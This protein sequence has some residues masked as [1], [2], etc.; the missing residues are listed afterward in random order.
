MA[1][2]ICVVTV[3]GT[4]IA[5]GTRDLHVSPAWIFPSS[6]QPGPVTLLPCP[7]GPASHS[8]CIHETNKEG[9][10][11]YHD[12]TNGIGEIPT[13]FSQRFVSLW[14]EEELDFVGILAV[15]P[16]ILLSVPAIFPFSHLRCTHA[17]PQHESQTIICLYG[18]LSCFVTHG[19]LNAEDH[20][21]NCPL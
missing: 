6:Y 2:D 4:C 5:F 15:G 3:L 11:S 1:V 20:S 14:E 13:S 9:Q 10:G 16:S 8:P 12:G 18:Q 19:P 17:G 21:P 7:S